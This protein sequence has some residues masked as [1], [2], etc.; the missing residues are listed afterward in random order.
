MPSHLSLL[1]T[2]AGDGNITGVFE[3]GPT[4]ESPQVPE[5]AYTLTGHYTETSGEITLVP[6]QWIRQPPGYVMVGLTGRLGAD[7]TRIDGQ[8]DH[9]NCERFTVRRFDG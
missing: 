9:Q 8:I 5:G 2:D 1:L 7:R 6:G 4:R 3:F